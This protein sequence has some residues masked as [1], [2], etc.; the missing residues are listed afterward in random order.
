MAADGGRVLAVVAG[1][2]GHVRVVQGDEA[3]RGGDEAACVGI[4]GVDH[5][6]NVAGLEWVGEVTSYKGWGSRREGNGRR[7]LSQNDF[8]S[9]ET[10]QFQVRPDSSASAVD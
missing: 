1:E 2:E 4:K 8:D 6:S 9:T 5:A 3:A 7:Q 10:E